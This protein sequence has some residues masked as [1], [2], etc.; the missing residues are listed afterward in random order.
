[1]NQELYT[2]TI[3][4]KEEQK[5]RMYVNQTIEEVIQELNY[6]KITDYDNFTMVKVKEGRPYSMGVL[7]ISKL[8]NL[9]EIT[10]TEWILVYKP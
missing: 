8:I 9:V 10:R 1:M 2:I 7:E 6:S 3:W 4:D 5:Q